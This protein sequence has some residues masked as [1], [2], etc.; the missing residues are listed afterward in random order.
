MTGFIALITVTPLAAEDLL[1]DARF[2]GLPSAL[3]IVGTAAGTSWLGGVMAR[4]GRRR[5]LL[6]GYFTAAI[7]AAIAA[8]A[9]GLSLFPL[10]LVA[11]FVLG[12]GYGSSRL[13]RY[14]AADL[15]EPERQARA[16]GFVVWAGTIGSVAGPVLLEPARQASTALSLPDVTGPFLLAAVAL[17]AAGLVLLVGFPADAPSSTRAPAKKGGMPLTH[18]RHADAQVALAALVIGQAVM[19]LIMTMTPIHVR[20]EGGGLQAV[21]MI[22]AAHTFGMYALSPLSGYLSDRV[23]RKPM[24]VIAGVF[25]VSSGV[26]SS[27][28][29]AD[30]TLLALGLFLLGWGW[31]LGFVSGS[32]LLT[33]AVPHEDRMRLQ[34]FSDSIV[35]ASAAAGGASSG[36]LLYATDYPTLCQLGALMA[37]VPA[38]MVAFRKP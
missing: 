18:L 21:G 1:G 10:L 7:A 17:G 24:I 22:I 6:L 3:A 38:A 4:R 37:V 26:I 13:S 32:A 31:N 9:V 27:R 25:L 19:V 34:G 2:S 5:G 33:A 29:G 20:R 15:Y 16:I 36:L 8:L 30:Q 35:W 23:G 11:I 14:A 12:A 28:A